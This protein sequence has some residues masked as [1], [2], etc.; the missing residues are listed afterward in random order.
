MAEWPTHRRK[1]RERKNRKRRTHLP[2]H[3]RHI[4]ERVN[5]RAG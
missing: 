1:A 2:A 4:I 5:R 3:V